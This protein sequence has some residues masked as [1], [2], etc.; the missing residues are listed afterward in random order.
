MQI[1]SSLAVVILATAGFA[2]PAAQ[3][4][5]GLFA[6]HIPRG[7]ACE[8]GNSILINPHCEDGLICKPTNAANP[9]EGICTLPFPTVPV[10]KRQLDLGRPLGSGCEVGNSI[11]INGCQFGLFCKANSKGS[12]FG[13][14]SK[15]SDIVNKPV[16]KRQLDLGRPLGSG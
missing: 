8:V 15:D 4:D 2:T 10:A 5:G 11:L 13:I 6:G 7:S 9:R 16:A 1:I 3:V 14:C 12:R